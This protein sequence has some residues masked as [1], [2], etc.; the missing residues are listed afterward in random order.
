MEKKKLHDSFYMYKKD[1][2]MENVV[3][4]GFRLQTKY[5][6]AKINKSGV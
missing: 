4:D 1:F 6:F 2:E 3:L 5:L